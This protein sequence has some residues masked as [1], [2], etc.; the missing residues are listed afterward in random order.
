MNIA[1]LQLLHRFTLLQKNQIILK[2]QSGKKVEKTNSFVILRGLKAIRGDQ[3]FSKIRLE[4]FCRE[5]MF[6]QTAKFQK[7]KND[8]FREKALRM[9]GR[10]YGQTNGQ[11]L[12]SRFFRILRRT[13]KCV[14]LLFFSP[15]FL[16]SAEDLN[17]SNCF[18]EQFSLNFLSP[19]M[20]KGRAFTS[21]VWRLLHV[22]TSF[23]TKNK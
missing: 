8:R 14:Y 1:N 21:C 5:C 12:N 17:F 15:H 9:D 3:I 19:S 18:I 23:G 20:S 22:S 7:K 10:T 11:G 16:P 4:H 2:S 6:Y 13:K